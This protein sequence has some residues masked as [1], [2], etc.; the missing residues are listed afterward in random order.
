MRT[1]HLLV[2]CAMVL[3][4]A[5]S[6]IAQQNVV[7]LSADERAG[8]TV[9]LWSGDLSEGATRAFDTAQDLT[10]GGA[11]DAFR[12]DM[13]QQPAAVAPILTVWSGE[14]DASI[15]EWTPYTVSA[16]SELLIPF[17][18]FVP[19]EGW[20]AD[21]A[22]ITRVDFAPGVTVSDVL[23]NLA[24]QLKGG[25]TLV[26]ESA[27]T[28]LQ[29]NTDGLANPGE[30]LRYNITITNS[31]TLN[32]TDVFLTDLPDAN[33]T[34]VDGL[35][36]TTSGSVVSGNTAG[37]TSVSVSIPL[38]GVAPCQP[39]VVVVRYQVEIDTPFFDVG[40]EV[41]DQA[42]LTSPDAPLA[43]TDD[44]ST[45]DANDPTCIAVFLAPEAVHTVDQNAD[46]VM[47]LNELLRV[48]QLYNALEFGCMNGTEDGYAPG[49]MDNSCTNH[50]ADY[51]NPNFSIELSELLR[52]IQ[53][54]SLENYYYCPDEVPATEDLFCAAV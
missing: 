33:V 54:F 3:V 37:D 7:R 19:L 38:V 34:L 36:Q 16:G 21:F 48:I 22:N 17:H 13:D 32:A 39:Q 35:V 28:L 40:D 12:L 23:T 4:M 25:A 27:L 47:A 31:G 41:C 29:N 50:D 51:L 10:E 15:W 45:L 1:L 9:A 49:G 44:P 26:A 5:S 14:G 43:L 46:G 30:A 53:F 18:E 11:I 6:A 2:L 24:V 52:Q 20:G 42:S 8:D